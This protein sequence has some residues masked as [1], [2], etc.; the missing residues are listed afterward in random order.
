[1]ATKLEEK[2]IEEELRYPIRL[3]EQVQAAVDEA[4]W[5]KLECC[6]VVKQVDRVSQM[7]QTMTRFAS[8]T[9]F[10]YDRSIRWVT[11]KVSKNLERALTLVRKCK[12]QSILRRFIMIVST[13]TTTN[14][15]VL[16]LH[17]RAM[18]TLVSH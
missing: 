18:A 4:N 6:E 14:H 1:M 2:M 7:L 9:Q 10:L 8:T 12:H 13:T 3:S 15:C 17:S 16:H 11:A 5:F